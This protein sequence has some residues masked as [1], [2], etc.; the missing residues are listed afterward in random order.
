MSSRS[1]PGLTTVAPFA[2]VTS[3]C[4]ASPPPAPG[5]RGQERPPGA[6]DERG[7]QD[8][9]LGVDV[10]RPC[11]P[12]VVLVDARPPAARCARR[13]DGGEGAAR[14]VAREERMPCEGGL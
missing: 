13:R 6:P 11:R 2:S 10:R 9:G 3:I 14:V 4:M 12:P 8:D 1:P 7:L 5:R